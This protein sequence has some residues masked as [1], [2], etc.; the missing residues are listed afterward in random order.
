LGR[1]RR[2]NHLKILAGER[3]D[4]INRGEPL[5]AETGVTP[6]APLTA[7]AEKVWNRLAPDLIDK[8]CLTS[9]DTDLFTVFCESAATYHDCRE[10]MGTDRLWV[11]SRRD[12][13]SSAPRT[14]KTVPTVLARIGV[15]EH[16]LRTV[17]ALLRF[18]LP[19]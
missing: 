19:T 6:P 1:P 11:P 12:S 10:R 14:G 3:E 8:G 4:R 16:S 2:P 15:S 5:P 17:G 13:T 7:G 9:W 18:R